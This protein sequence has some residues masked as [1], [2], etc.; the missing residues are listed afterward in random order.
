MRHPPGRLSYRFGKSTL[1][2]Q[3]AYYIR[4]SLSVTG[5]T[6]GV[7]SRPSAAH[8][9]GEGFVQRAGIKEFTVISES[10]SVLIR[11]HVLHRLLE[12]EQEAASDDANREAVALST[13]NYRFSLLGCESGGGRPLYVM[14]VEPLRGNKFLY[15]GMIWI[16]AQDFAVSRIEAEPAQNPSYW[17][18]H[19]QIR[20]RYQKIGEFY[21]PAL[22]QTTTDMRFG[23]KAVLTIQY[24]DY[25]LSEE[26]ASSHE[27]VR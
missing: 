4:G 24:L 2:F 5:V 10:G 23:G 25:K 15:R 6:G 26:L 21:L 7:S 18:L 11:K 14:R 20:H 27:T 13:A 3:I 12:S 22:N 19:S 9:A 8:N 17:I 16:D 1:R